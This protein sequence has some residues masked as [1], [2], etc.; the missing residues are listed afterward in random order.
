M[1]SLLVGMLGVLFSLYIILETE[2]DFKYLCRLIFCRS[3]SN[4]ER[5]QSRSKDETKD[6]MNIEVTLF[7]S[8][9]F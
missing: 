7:V 1:S 2:Q 4:G 5:K 6:V 9:C 8:P 3:A